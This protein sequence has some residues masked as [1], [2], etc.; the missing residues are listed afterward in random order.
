MGDLTELLAIARAADNHDHNTLR[1]V[2][3]TAAGITFDACDQCVAD[4]A[5]AAK[6][7]PSVKRIAVQIVGPRPGR[8]EEPEPI[9][10]SAG[11]V[12]LFGGESPND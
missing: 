3:V 8:R 6:A 11:Q 12:P 10:V 5:T 2:R 4:V 1:P 9:A 7:A